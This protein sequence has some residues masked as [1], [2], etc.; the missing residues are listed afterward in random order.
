MS[1]RQGE[2]DLGNNY[3]T[4]NEEIER[5]NKKS[6]WFVYAGVGVWYVGMMIWFGFSIHKANLNN[7]SHPAA[8]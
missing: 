8:I 6:F 5:L 3:E 7:A 1:T 4:Q 2:A